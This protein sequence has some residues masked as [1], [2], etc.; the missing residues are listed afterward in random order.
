[1]ISRESR[2]VVFPNF[3]PEIS[4]PSRIPS[5][6]VI[7]KHF[8][9]V[10]KRVRCINRLTQKRGMVKKKKKEKTE[11]EREREEKDRSERKKEE[12]EGGK[13]ES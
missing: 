5:V 12:I 7:H 1:M 4:F 11:R 10:E 13:L 9:F 8:H 6:R 3:H 2:I